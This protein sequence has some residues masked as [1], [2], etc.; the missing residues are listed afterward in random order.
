MSKLP[1]DKK[2]VCLYLNCLLIRRG[3]YVSL[4]PLDKKG[5]FCV[6]IAS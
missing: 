4:L 3:I 6:L 5:Y 2:G 1:L